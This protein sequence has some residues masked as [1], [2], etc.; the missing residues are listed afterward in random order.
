[1]QGNFKRRAA[2]GVLCITLTGSLALGALAADP[3]AFKDIP[4]GWA[5]DAIIYAI[6]NDLFH[7]D[8]QGYIRPNATMT[9]AEMA[10][11]LN[12]ALGAT[13]TAKINFSDVAQGAWY[14][15]TVQKAVQMG[16]FVGT[17]DTTFSPELGITRESAFLALANSLCLSAADTKALDAYSD[18]D[19]ISPWARNAIAA[20]VE[21]GYVTGNAGRILPKDTITRA[22]FVQVMYN[23]F[24]EYIV[25]TGEV[26]QFGDGN[27]VIRVSGVTAKKAEVKGDLIVGD[28]VGS[29]SFRVDD[30]KIA[31]RLLVRGGGTSTIYVYGTQVEEGVYI[32]NVNSAV[33]LV[34]DRNPSA[35][36]KLDVTATTDVR[37]EGSFGTVTVYPDA[38]VTVKSGAK[39]D[40]FVFMDGATEAKNVVYEKSGGGGGGGGGSSPSTTY[41]YDVILNAAGKTVS[42]TN[43]SASTRVDAVI[44]ELKES[45]QISYA[46]E[47][48]IAKAE[49]KGILVGGVVQ[50]VPY[51]V[52]ITEVVPDIDQDIANDLGVEPEVVN[53]VLDKLKD[54]NLNPDNFDEDEKKV[55]VQL[56]GYADK[57]NS[58]K[59]Y[60]DKIDQKLQEMKKDESLSDAM[61]AAIGSMT[62][63]TVKDAAADYAAQ[64]DDLLRAWGQKSVSLRA[65][66]LATTRAIKMEVQLDPIDIAKELYPTYTQKAHDEA[67][68]VLDKVG[69]AAVDEII[70]LMDPTGLVTK[71][72]DNY[73]KIQDVAAYET[74]VRNVLD[75]V[76]I[77]R[78]CAPASGKTEA[79]VVKYLADKI[80]SKNKDVSYEVLTKNIEGLRAKN[81]TLESWYEHVGSDQDLNIDFTIDFAQ[82]D[83]EIKTIINKY[84]DGDSISLKINIKMTRD[85]E[86]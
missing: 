63:E 82:F 4:E 15:S 5:K 10:T 56:Q 49:A 50:K 21:N 48:A 75:Q 8:G 84:Y 13:A 55:V 28:G 43:R 31:G 78:S 54:E 6:Q 1:M 33:L 45:N 71:Q 79:D 12:Q 67:A 69:V 36:N 40:K 30:S 53:S 52:E 39:V 57:I 11:V 17:S 20:L 2:T 68:A 65:T 62:V 59:D 86:N 41:Y 3:S 60:D 25:K 16:T 34:T 64:L 77:I 72:A 47:Q 24:P 29:G 22:E 83:E 76:K 26:S 70:K 51:E 32:H 85:T 18:K 14:Y 42:Y 46:I 73:Y 23:L 35:A 27:V 7:G 38:V 9:R 74:L 61:K 81:A 44:D 80:Y 66:S 19:Q 37:L 58:S